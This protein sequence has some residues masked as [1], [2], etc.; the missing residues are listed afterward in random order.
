MP[1][2]RFF[3]VRA[4]GALADRSPSPVAT[5]NAVGGRKPLHPSPANSLV[6][7]EEQ[8][9]KSEEGERLLSGGRV[10]PSRQAKLKKKK[11]RDRKRKRHAFR[12]HEKPLLEASHED[13]RSVADADPH[14]DVGIY[15]HQDQDTESDTDSSS[16]SDAESTAASSVVSLDEAAEIDIPSAEEDEEDGPDAPSLRH[17]VPVTH[18]TNNP[19]SK[20][21]GRPSRNRN[22]NTVA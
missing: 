2:T 11:Y 18:G 9:K 12:P 5:G 15:P 14:L 3:G 16:S 13:T 6:K 19:C 7:E 1:I 4:P 20:S 22:N 17:Q 21:C 10:Q 8:R